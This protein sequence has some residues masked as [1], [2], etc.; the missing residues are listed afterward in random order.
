MVLTH[1]ISKQLYAIC[2]SLE[3]GQPVSLPT[4]IHG[5]LLHLMWRVDTEKGSY[6]IKQLSKNIKLTLEV[7]KSYEISERVAR[8][9]STHGI[10]AISGIEKD[11][12]FLVDSENDTFLIYPWVEAKILDRNAVSTLHAVRIGTLLAKMHLLNLHVPEIESPK[13]DIHSNEEIMT[14]IEKSMEMSLPFANK[15]QQSSSLLIKWNDEY[16]QAVHSFRDISVVSHADLD[17]KNVLWDENDNPILIDWESVRALNPTY[18]LLIAALDWSG[19]TSGT[20][21]VELFKAIIAAYKKAGG[22]IDLATLNANFYG[23]PG[24]GI[25]WMVYNIRRSL[26]M[27]AEEKELGIEQVNQALKTMIYLASKVK[28]LKM[29]MGTLDVYPRD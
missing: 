27:E 19:A 13:Y 3:L 25:S 15:L 20:L 5:G 22:T 11:G 1:M 23:I 2:T 17:Q 26:N 29:T 4:K 7:R 24:N 18:E 10:P 16:Q 6:A 28:D 12:K 21:N 14:L 9:F 8:Q